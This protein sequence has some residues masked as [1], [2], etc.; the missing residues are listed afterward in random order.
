MCVS[1]TSFFRLEFEKHKEVIL[2]DYNYSDFSAINTIYILI[3]N[4][5]PKISQV[6][7]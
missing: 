7:A 6:C 1:L 4:I 2:H 5:D 3:F